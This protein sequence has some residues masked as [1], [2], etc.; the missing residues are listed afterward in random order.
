MSR[1]IASALPEINI[2]VRP[3][4]TVIAKIACLSI[5]LRPRHVDSFAVFHV[6]IRL[7]STYST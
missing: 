3:D 7:S 2:I 4:A 6:D 5:R 1:E